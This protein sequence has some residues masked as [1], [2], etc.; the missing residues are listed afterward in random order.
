[1][2]NR[3]FNPPKRPSNPGAGGNREGRGGRG[4]GGR[5]NRGKPFGRG[6]WG[7]GLGAGAGGRGARPTADGAAGR[8]RGG[9]AGRGRGAAHGEA[10]NYGVETCRVCGLVGC[11]DSSHGHLR[12]L[13]ERPKVQD[14]P[15]AFLP[16][17]NFFPQ[18]DLPEGTGRRLHDVYCPNCLKFKS[19]HNKQPWQLDE[20]EEPCATCPQQ[21]SPG[22]TDYFCPRR[23]CTWGWYKNDMARVPYVDEGISIMP[24]P[25][26]VEQ[27]SAMEYRGLNNMRPLTAIRQEKR[28]AEELTPEGYMERLKHDIEEH[29][30][31]THQFSG[32]FKT[33]NAEDTELKARERRAKEACC[34]IGGHASTEATQVPLP[35]VT[36]AEVEAWAEELDEVSARHAE[37]RGRKTND[38]AD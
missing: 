32:A 38:D 23:W 17:R 27:L 24:S 19:Q 14:N 13:M 25:D 4:L 6:A 29:A 9:G 3:G 11:S 37:Q 28:K 30:Q 10:A 8:G 21:H 18:A 20:W 7:G 34:R 22:L 12:R 2:S 15:K 35:P 33:T 31:R 5:G 36:E 1:M 26:E 16:L